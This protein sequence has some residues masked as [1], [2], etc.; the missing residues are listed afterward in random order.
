MVHDVV[1]A[2]SEK[3]TLASEQTRITFRTSDAVTHASCMLWLRRLSTRFHM[4]SPKRFTSSFA[5]ARPLPSLTIQLTEQED[6]LCTL[7]DECS[8]SIHEAKPDSPPV[9]CRI[10]GG[11]VRDKVWSKAVLADANRNSAIDLKSVVTRTTFER[12]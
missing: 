10:A 11:W 5:P 4:A 1:I 7:L 12:H 3:T 9:E 8:K 6:Q 2:S